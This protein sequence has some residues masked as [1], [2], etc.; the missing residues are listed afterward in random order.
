MQLIGVSTDTAD[1][2]EAVQGIVDD[3]K[4]SFPIVH[5][6]SLGRS[7]DINSIP[8]IRV[9]DKAGQIV[10]RSRGY[11]KYSIEQL[12]AVVK[13]LETEAVAGSELGVFKSRAGGQL[14]LKG[15]SPLRALGGFR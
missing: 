2:A 13:G 11:S 4:L 15:A 7:F 12:D 14:S 8:S 5:S 6:S 1:K 10:Y 9:L 3:L